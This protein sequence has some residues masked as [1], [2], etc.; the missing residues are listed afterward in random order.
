[1]EMRGAYRGSVGAYEGKNPLGRPSV[2]GKI[3]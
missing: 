2:D 3:I 1:M